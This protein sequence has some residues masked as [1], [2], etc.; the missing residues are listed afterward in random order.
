M[1]NPVLVLKTQ[2]CLCQQSEKL[3]HKT[4]V[5]VD[6]ETLSS[7]IP[8]TKCL[9]PPLVSDD[10]LWSHFQPKS[11]NGMKKVESIPNYKGGYWWK[12]WGTTQDGKMT[13]VSAIKPANQVRV[14]L[15]PQSQ[16]CLLSL[17][18]TGNFRQ[19]EG[20]RHQVKLHLTGWNAHR[21][22][23]IWYKMCAQNHNW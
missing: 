21:Y 12:D 15:P 5:P 18:H 7:C 20:S 10:P 14:C 16:Y 2:V 1:E 23:S 4:K 6:W 19:G 22:K 17:C 9:L 11:T 3:K 8:L 13:I